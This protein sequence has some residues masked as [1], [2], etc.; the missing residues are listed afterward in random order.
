MSPR[1]PV[2]AR[3]AL[4]A[5]GLTLALGLAEL[6]AR[7]ADEGALPQLAAFT[8]APDGRVVLAAD[9]D[10]RVRRPDGAVYRVRTGAHGLRDP[11]P[12]APDAPVDLP[13]SGWLVVGDSQVFGSGVEDH[14][15]F[16][17]HLG[18]RNAGVPGYG[19]P[20]ALAQAA[21]LVP[22][23]RPAGVLVL[24][25]QANDLDDGLAP[26]HER[27]VVRGGW[28]LTR[29][30]AG[31]TWG[32]ETPLARSHLFYLFQAR[33]APPVPPP[34]FLDPD[35]ALVA[36]F[37]AALDG[38]AR[39]HAVRTVAAWL[40]VDAATSA[41]RAARSPFPIGAATPWTDTRLRDTL[42]AALAEVPLIDLL[43]ALRDPACF[44]DRDFHLSPAGH[45]AVAA[46]L[47]EALE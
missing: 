44:L 25:D 3:L 12:D 11:A 22:V 6:A 20:D 40:P 13:S 7:L 47:N 35:P 33:R 32:W 30:T 14:E 21:A 1:V 26:A 24:V 31:S 19:L 4:A 9:V 27:Y 2:T 10:T 43:P 42:A 45:A 23:L 15:T 16:A 39:A 38:F 41:E 36:T 37:A 17:A 29:A 28:L 46:R 18:F 5:F 34:A 8:Y